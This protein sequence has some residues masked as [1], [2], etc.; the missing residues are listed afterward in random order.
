MRPHIILYDDY[1]D[2]GN[3]IET[4]Q[5]AENIISYIKNH[6]V[7][8]IE[9]EFDIHNDSI[10]AYEYGSVKEVMPDKFSLECLGNKGGLYIY[11]I[12]LPEPY[13]T[14]ELFT[15]LNDLIDDLTVLKEDTYTFTLKSGHPRCID[16]TVE[17]DI[18]PEIIQVYNEPITFIRAEWR[19]R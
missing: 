1:T 17:L 13:N 14:L 4:K 16:Y 2:C 12:D 18:A 11:Q 6:A 9:P 19:D 3:I 15:A 8:E 10:G 5:I 7:Y